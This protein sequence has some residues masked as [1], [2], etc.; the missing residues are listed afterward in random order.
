ML[1]MD[2]LQYDFFLI[3]SF[4]SHSFYLNF[5]RLSNRLNPLNIFKFFLSNRTMNVFNMDSFQCNFISIQSL[6]MNSS[7]NNFTWLSDWLKFNKFLGLSLNKL[8]SLSF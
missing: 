2:T 6:L 7:K 8:S 3:N 5:P 4:K 1:N